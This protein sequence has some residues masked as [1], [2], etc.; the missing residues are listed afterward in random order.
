MIGS[1]GKQWKIFPGKNP[2][3]FFFKRKASRFPHSFR[4][5]IQL[6]CHVFRFTAKIIITQFEI[7]VKRFSALSLLMTLVFGTNYHYFSVSLDYLALIAHGFYGRSDFHFEFLS[8][9]VICLSQDL[10]RQVILPFVKS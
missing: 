10:L 7:H 1:D 5:E 2:L 4:A 9:C 6:Y 8:F 3:V